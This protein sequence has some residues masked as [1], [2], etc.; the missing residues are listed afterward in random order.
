MKNRPTRF[1]LKDGS[2]L[3]GRKV[4]V[5]GD[6][7]VIRAENGDVKLDAADILEEQNQTTLK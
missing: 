7:V 5:S 6:R 4:M 2:V 1:T 3:L